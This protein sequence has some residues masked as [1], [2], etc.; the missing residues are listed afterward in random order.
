MLFL[1][2][3]FGNVTKFNSASLHRWGREAPC[4]LPLKKA[5]PKFTALW[6]QPPHTP[7]ALQ[8]RPT[9]WT[10]LFIKQQQ[11]SGMCENI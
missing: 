6:M 2:I 10:K 7:Y 3:F 5:F 11:K 9:E 1:I 4:F 8:K